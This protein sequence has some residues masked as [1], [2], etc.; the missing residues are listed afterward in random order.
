MSVHDETWDRPICSHCG[1]EIKYGEKLRHKNGKCKPMN[2]LTTN[3]QTLAAFDKSAD[4]IIETIEQLGFVTE[5]P[6]ADGYLK[7]LIV[8][9]LQSNLMGNTNYNVATPEEHQSEDKI[10][11]WF[12]PDDEKETPFYTTV[13]PYRKQNSAGDLPPFDGIPADDL[14][15]YR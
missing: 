7:K 9:T 13:E 12:K 6:I 15:Y 1:Y 4:E 10:W 2:T 14:G 8:A 5:T 3:T 11:G